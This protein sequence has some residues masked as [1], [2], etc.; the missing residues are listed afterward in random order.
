S[1]GFADDLVGELAPTLELVG[2]RDDPPLGEVAHRALDLEVLG[3]EGE[4]HRWGLRGAGGAPSLTTKGTRSEGFDRVRGCVRCVA[5]RRLAPALEVAA[6]PL[7]FCALEA[8]AASPRR[9]RA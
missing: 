6:A 5:L 2:D 8:G 4:V 7:L 1:G 3:R 9:G